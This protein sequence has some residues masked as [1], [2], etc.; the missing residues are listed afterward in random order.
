MFHACV[1]VMAPGCFDS[2]FQ[3]LVVIDRLTDRLT[4]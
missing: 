2:R 3:L 1:C 4:D